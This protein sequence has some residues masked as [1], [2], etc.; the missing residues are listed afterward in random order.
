MRTRLRW[1]WTRRRWKAFQRAQRGNTADKVLVWY[2]NGRQ[3][4]AGAAAE[5]FSRKARVG[6]ESVSGR[7]WRWLAGELEVGQPDAICVCKRWW[8]G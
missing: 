4:A 2:W 6:G 5:R 7:A 1:A 3:L 8:A